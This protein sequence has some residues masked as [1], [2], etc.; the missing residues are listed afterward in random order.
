MERKYSDVQLTP[1]N[2]HKA[3]SI[4]I[5]TESTQNTAVDSKER[6]CD[7]DADATANATYSIA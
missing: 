1:S 2:E 7:A 3:H 6:Y 5:F 4:L